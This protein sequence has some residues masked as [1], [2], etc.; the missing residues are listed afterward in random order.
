VKNKRLHRAL[1][2]VGLCLSLVLPSHGMASPADWVFLDVEI[3]GAPQEGWTALAVLGDQ[4]AAVG[5]RPDIEPWIGPHTRVIQGQGRSLIPGLIDSH[6]HAARAGLT[7]TTEVSWSGVKRLSDA[8]KLLQLKA[9]QTQDS[10]WIVVAGGWVPEQFKEGRVPTSA[11]LE[12][13]VG[14]RA[15]Y[16]QRGY[17]SVWISTTGMQRLAWSDHA[18]LASRLSNERDHNGHETGWL[19][20]DARTISSVYD[21]LPPADTQQQ[22]ESSWTWYR[23]LAAWGLT[24]VI[25]PGGYN[26]PPE[27]MWATQSLWRDQKLPIRIRYH[28]SAPRAHHE[29][30]DFQRL[31]EGL[32]TD[33]GDDLW[34]FNGWGENVT[35]GMY[36]NAKPSLS[37]QAELKEVL[38]WAAQQKLGMTFH[39]NNDDNVGSL[40]DVIEQVHQVHGVSAL[41]WS[42]AHLNNASTQSLQ[43]MK[44]LGMGWLVQNASHF[45]RAAMARNWGETALQHTPPLAQALRLGLPVG[46]GTDAH[47]VMSAH[48]FIS[49][50]WA[51]DGLSVDGKPTRSGPDLLTRRQALHAY[52]QGSAWF[53]HE[54]GR[55]GSLQTGHLADLVLLNDSYLS[56]DEHKI[57]TLRSDLT[58]VGGRQVHP[59]PVQ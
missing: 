25:D 30:G 13:A 5:H 54:E 26:L 50:Q 10:D 46:L 19:T 4:I 28:L 41:R 42:I 15:A 33:G 11:E 37:D 16:I 48:P 44:D 18:E 56:I 6:I 55:R 17:Q 1:C 21:M 49:I 58:L 45:Q 52:T 2:W 9:K 32:P 59:P 40:L 22:K 47:R 43:R 14:M 7:W 29:L 39:W 36:N 23:Q 8:L 27:A 3:V 20:G 57:H 38:T 51:V 53:S 31:T 34:R 24:G 12:Q 35:W